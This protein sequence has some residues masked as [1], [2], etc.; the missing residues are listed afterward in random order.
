MSRNAPP[1]HAAPSLGFPTHAA[2]SGFPTHAAPSLGFPTHAAPSLV[3]L[4]AV[5]FLSCSEK[6]PSSPPEAVSSGRKRSEPADATAVVGSLAAEPPAPGRPQKENKRRPKSILLAEARELIAWRVADGYLSRN[7]IIGLAMGSADERESLRGDVEKMVDEELLAHKRREQEW[8]F[9]TDAD[10]LTRAF[11]ILEHQGVLAR[12]RYADCRKCGVAD[13]RNE[14]ENQI[15]KG[16]TPLGY[17]FFTD[18]DIEGISD[19]GELVLEFGSFRADD[20]EARKRIGARVID[21]LRKEG[22]TVVE[23]SDEG[24]SYLVLTELNWQKRR[25]TRPPRAP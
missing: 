12:E 4:V 18:Q 24:E 14:R 25:F 3:V 22:L 1:N 2:P 7:E 11:V 17:V 5:A 19:S 21:A 10:R 9:P 8:K 15:E 23:E 13:I 20:D 6:E 16:K